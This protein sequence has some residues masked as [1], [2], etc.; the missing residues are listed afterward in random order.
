MNNKI[1]QKVSE[2]IKKKSSFLFFL[3]VKSFYLWRSRFQ[4]YEYIYIY[5]SS[6]HH[7]QLPKSGNNLD[8]Q[9]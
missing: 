8:Y 5:I 4:N 3:K 9:L 6:V 1:F 7:N 2:K